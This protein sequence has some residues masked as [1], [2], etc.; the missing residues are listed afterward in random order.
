MGGTPRAGGEVQSGHPDT[1]G[2]SAHW[3]RSADVVD[4]CGDGALVSRRLRG[5]GK[6]RT[7]TMN[8]R[9]TDGDRR[10][11]PPGTAESSGR[12]RP[13]VKP[14]LTEYGSIAKLTQG[15]KTT[16]ADAAGGGFKMSCL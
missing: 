15:T 7:T 12:R 2:R 11:A 9:P 16:Q 13:Y 5:S 8:D 14:V 4:G 1:G 6:G 10:G 3:P